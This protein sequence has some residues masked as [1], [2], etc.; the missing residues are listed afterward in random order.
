M[1]YLANIENVWII[2]AIAVVALLFLG[3]NKIPEL[4][5]GI[6]Q[7]VRELKKGMSHDEDDEL[8]KDA[9]RRKEVEARVEEQMRREEEERRAAGVKKE[10]I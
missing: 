3:G 10:S 4:M 9:T 2:V 8:K 1:L 7:C 6:G 5:K